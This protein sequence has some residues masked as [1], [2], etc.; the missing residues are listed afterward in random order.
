MRNHG[1]EMY[2]A[3]YKCVLGLLWA[4]A[5]SKTTASLL[6]LEQWLLDS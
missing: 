4:N 5:G 6:S 3:G 1:A 2:Y